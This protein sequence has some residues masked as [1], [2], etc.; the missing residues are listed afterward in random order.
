[1]TG[2]S[3]VSWEQETAFYPC[4]QD[5]TT[6]SYC[7]RTC[8]GRLLSD[9]FGYAQGTLAP[10]L[11]VTGAAVALGWGLFLLLNPF[12]IVLVNVY[13]WLYRRQLGQAC[14]GFSRSGN[15]LFVDVVQ[16]KVL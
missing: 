7:S 11:R 10:H 12:W 2:R 16:A 4:Q 5:R 13:H 14:A 9:P 15:H 8:P 6:S 1:M 3:A